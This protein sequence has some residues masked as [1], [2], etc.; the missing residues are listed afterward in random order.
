MRTTYDGKDLK[1]ELM[2]VGVDIVS[3]VKGILDTHKE[4][5]TAG[6]S[7]ENLKGYEFGI[8]TVF[9]Q[10]NQLIS[11]NVEFVEDDGA[12]ESTEEAVAETQSEESEA[13]AEEEEEYFCP[14]CGAKI[15]LDMTHCPKCGVEFEFEE[16]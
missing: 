15:T 1:E 3:F 12:E 4:Q 14:E 5:I 9:D 13:P 11:E 8:N 16:E 2:F 10:I 7:N 6:M